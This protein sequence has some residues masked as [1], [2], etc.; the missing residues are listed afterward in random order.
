MSRIHVSN[1]NVESPIT[2]MDLDD[3]QFQLDRKTYPDRVD[4]IRMVRACRTS[5]NDIEEDAAGEKILEDRIEELIDKIK[6]Q[7]EIN[8]QLKDER[9]E[10]GK[11]I[12]GLLNRIEELESDQEKKANEIFQTNGR[13][14][15]LKD[16]L[17]E[18]GDAKLVV[19][20]LQIDIRFLQGQLKN[21]EEEVAQSK[22][23]Y[24]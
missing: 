20:K 18:A 12:T 15:Y 16:C 1:A 8:K 17:K 7:D 19:E 6:K 24:G 5:I 2:L 11:T 13:I 22:I 4:I 9:H 10:L 21:M 14:I 23:V 3:I